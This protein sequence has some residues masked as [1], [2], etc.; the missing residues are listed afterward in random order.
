MP[1]FPI[2]ISFPISVCE[3]TPCEFMYELVEIRD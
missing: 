2:I 3:R 1:Y